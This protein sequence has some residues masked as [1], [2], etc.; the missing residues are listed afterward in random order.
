MYYTVANDFQADE[1]LDYDMLVFFSPEGI[2]SLVKNFPNFEQGDVWIACLGSKTVNEAKKAGLRVDLT[3]TPELR[4]VPAMIEEFA[5]S[6]K[7]SH[8]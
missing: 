6:T 5:K 7:K 1:K 2:H 4:S 3:V 8:A